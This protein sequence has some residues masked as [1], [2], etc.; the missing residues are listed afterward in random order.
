MYTSKC[1]VHLIKA[2]IL[3]NNRINA[4]CTYLG[5]YVFSV[6]FAFGGG[7]SENKV[8]I[9]MQNPVE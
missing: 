3:H 1:F 5:F 8:N 2:S 4:L 7:D 9:L 6:A